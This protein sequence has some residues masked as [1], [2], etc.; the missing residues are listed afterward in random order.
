MHIYIYKPKKLKAM[1]LYVYAKLYLGVQ[2]N[3]NFKIEELLSE[4][5]KKNNNHPTIFLNNK[6]AFLLYF[7]H[8][9]SEKICSNFLISIS[10]G[11]L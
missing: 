9:Y 11:Y 8:F 4:K 1:P 2:V 6:L 7:Q 5:K 10:N 3:N